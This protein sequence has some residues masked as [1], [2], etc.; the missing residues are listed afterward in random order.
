MSSDRQGRTWL[1]ALRLAAASAVVVDHAFL[2]AGHPT[3]VVL[4]WSNRSLHLGG[5]AVV[6]F[7]VLSGYLVTSSWLHQPQLAPFLRKRVLR[8]W[9][10]LLVALAVSTLVLGPLMTTL[11]VAAYLTD[12][13][14]WH[15]LRGALLMPVELHLPGVFTDN[16]GTDYVN[17]SLWTLPLEVLCYCLLGIAGMLGLLA[18]RWPVPLAACLALVATQLIPVLSLTGLGDAVTFFLLGASARLFALP[19]R[20]RYAAAA[21]ALLIASVVAGIYTVGAFALAYSVLYVGTRQWGP[22]ARSDRWGD[23]SYG[24]YVYGYPVQ[25]TFVALGLTA[26]WP[27]AVVSGVVV[28]LLGYA[29][30]HLV[31]KR[32]LAWGRR[33]PQNERTTASTNDVALDERAVPVALQAIPS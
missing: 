21:A 19:M 4:A 8:I 33:R 10:A 32:A 28:V 18:R 3:P 26:V 17:G 1:A 29:S 11:P 15:Y 23:P 20:A 27:L 12:G 6:V 14:T 9:P 22:L 31:E 13:G 30:W 24:V 16:P 5:F 7:F 2:L 25:Q